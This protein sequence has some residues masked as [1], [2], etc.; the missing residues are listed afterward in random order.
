MGE[1]LF[2]ISKGRTQFVA[3][4]IKTLYINVQKG[5]RHYTGH[6][7]YI[8]CPGLV[9]TQKCVV[10]QAH[11]DF[12]NIDHI[13][14][15]FGKP[16]IMHLPLCEEGMYLNIWSSV[17]KKILHIPQFVH[18]PFGAFMLLQADVIHGGVFGEPSNI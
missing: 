2:D 11:I 13:P 12:Q 5:L 3:R 6:T 16:W 17:E 8:G 14:S 4:A 10:Q 15:D 9:L 7:G 18:I 1:T